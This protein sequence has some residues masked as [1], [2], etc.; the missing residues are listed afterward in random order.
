MKWKVDDISR[1]VASLSVL[2]EK[3]NKKIGLIMDV[4]EKRGGVVAGRPKNKRAVAKST[5]E[6][7]VE[8]RM[9]KKRSNPEVSLV[10]CMIE[11]FIH[12][13]IIYSQWIKETSKFTVSGISD[14]RMKKI[15]EVLIS[16][17]DSPSGTAIKISKCIWDKSYIENYLVGPQTR[18][19]RGNERQ[20]FL[21]PEEELK[22]KGE[23]F[24][25]FLQM[26]VSFMHEI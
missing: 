20:D 5:Y 19:P 24:M 6:S 21:P 17:P 18:A 12:V 8:E 22:L 3:M 16:G 15:R 26:N 9:K 2:L 11:S 1:N 7:N 10:S 14:E 13:F 25:C 23:S 4:M